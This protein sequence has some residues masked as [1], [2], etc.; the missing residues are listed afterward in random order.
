MASAFGFAQ[1]PYLTM[2]H[3]ILKRNPQTYMV[4]DVLQHDSDPSVA[5]T[6]E[7]AFS[8]KYTLQPLKLN[9]GQL[10]RAPKC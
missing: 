2:F 3:L 5:Q 1:D 10:I 6:G 4:G 8:V 7:R 9:L